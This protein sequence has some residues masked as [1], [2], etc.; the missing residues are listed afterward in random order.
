VLLSK[1]VIPYASTVM[2]ATSAFVR[3][4]RLKVLSLRKC[5]RDA[6]S[7][8]TATVNTTSIHEDIKKGSA[9]PGQMTP[10]ARL[11]PKKSRTMPSKRRE[12]RTM[13]SKNSGVC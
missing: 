3:T 12:S 8:P 6:S 1:N 4:T 2:L 9:A 7:K 13:P 5:A 10:M 11:S